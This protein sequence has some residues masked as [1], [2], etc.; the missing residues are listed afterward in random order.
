M[1]VVSL[2]PSATEIVYALGIEPVGVSHECDFPNAAR[3]KPSMNFSRVDS[4]ASSEEIDRQVRAA[5]RDHGGVYGIDREALAAADPDLIV[6]QGVCDVCAVDRV[7]VR[8]TVEELD[9]DTE[10]LTLD[11]HTLDE[12]LED[13]V[14]IGAATGREASAEEVVAG[15]RE[16][17]D[18]VAS[19]TRTAE[20]RPQVAILDWLDP[21]M[22]AGHW[23]PEIVRLA[24]GEYELAEPGDASTIREWDEVLAYDPDVLIAAPCGFGL[25]QATANATDV[26]ER[27][28]FATLTATRTGTVY[29]MDGHHYVNRPGPR[30]VDTLEYLAGLL[31][32]DRM[33]EPSDEVVRSIR[34]PA[35]E[36]ETSAERG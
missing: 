4:E 19:R 23:M 2:L 20:E 16:R 28:G 22:V 35:S 11:S 6:T 33:P 18:A 27:E 29:L 9:L 12:V 34:D 25:D 24:G 36:T 7:L 31:H 32:A 30:L 26:T 13:I 10:V 1:R 14:R 5:E 17:I 15:L 8:E 21:V 3:E